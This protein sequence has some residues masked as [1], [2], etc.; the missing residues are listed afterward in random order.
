MREE[1]AYDD[2][3]E[4]ILLADYKWVF[5]KPDE[6]YRDGDRM[7]RITYYKKAPMLKEDYQR[8][9]KRGILSRKEYEMCLKRPK[10]KPKEVEE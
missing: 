2:C 6:E 3:Y 1:D 9:L 8:N 4:G 5:D 10:W 7:V